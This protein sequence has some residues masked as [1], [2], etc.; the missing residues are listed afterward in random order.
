[1]EQRDTNAILAI[2][3]E[4]IDPKNLLDSPKDAKEEEKE[5]Y[6]KQFSDIYD[7]GLRH[8]YYLISKY[9]EG[10]SSDVYASLETWLLVLVEYGNLNF[11]DT[12]GTKGLE[13]LLDHVELESIRL[14]RMRLVYSYSITIQQISEDIR[15]TATNA[16]NLVDAAQK[17]TEKIHEQSVAILSI[18]SAVVLAFMGGISFSSSTLESISAASMFR[19][20]ITIL[21]LG[22]VLFNSIFILMRF[23]DYIVNQNDSERFKNGISNF[24]KAIAIIAVILV[25]LYSVGLGKYIEQWGEKPQ[26]NSSVSVV[27]TQE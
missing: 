26:A 17:Q 5:S 22:F 7:T 16:A 10:Q 20:L 14:D 12:P 23:V 13:K 21:L 9:L 11:P 2:F 8:S 25:V 24:N 18:F 27:E 4:L 6:Y 3:D 15:T 19:L 1:M